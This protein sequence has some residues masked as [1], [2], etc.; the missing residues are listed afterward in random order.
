MH[1]Q[2]CPGGVGGG[3][4]V[5]GKSSRFWPEPSYMSLLCVSSSGGSGETGCKG[6]KVYLSFSACI[7][8]KEPK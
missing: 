3:G 2:L 4:G 8:T 6:L 5:E 7:C 1:E